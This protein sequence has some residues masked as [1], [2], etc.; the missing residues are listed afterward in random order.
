M[1]PRLVPESTNEREVNEIGGL[2]DGID[3]GEF[4]A[5]V[6]QYRDKFYRLIFSIVREAAPAEE[7]T[8]D[9]FLKI[10]R[11]LDRYDGRALVG[12]WIS[13][14]ARNTGL[15]CPVQRQQSRSAISMPASRG[16]RP[17]KG[18]WWSNIIFKTVRL[19]TPQLRWGW[20]VDG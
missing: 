7:L 5:V 9:V 16:Q 18:K 4:E 11:L 2:S 19:R 3:R 1:Q 6:R 13:P 14:I 20:L 8:Q 10:W 17:I 15:P 12:T